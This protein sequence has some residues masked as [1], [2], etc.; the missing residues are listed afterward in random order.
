M[1]KITSAVFQ[2]SDLAGAKRREFLGAAR[3]LPP[4]PRP[5]DLAVNNGHAAFPIIAAS[6]TAPGT[7]AS[8]LVDGNY[9]YNTDPPNRW[10]TTGSPHRAD[11]VTIDFGAARVLDSVQLYLLDDSTGVRAPASYRLAVWRNGSWR[12]LAGEHPTPARPAGHRANTVSFAPVSASRLL[13]VLVPQPGAAVGMTEVE[14]W[15]NGPAPLAAPTAPSPDRAWGARASASFTSRYDSF[16]EINDMVVAFS[17]Y[18]RNRWTSYGSPNRS[19]WIELDFPAARMVSRVELDL[20]GD[21]GGTRAPKRYT[22]QYRSGTDWVDA[23]VLSQVPVAPQVSSANTVTIAPV[24]T[25]GI[26]VV[27]EP[28]TPA[29]VGVTEVIIRGEN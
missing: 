7:A 25:A 3:Q 20:W 12:Q 4:P 9:W 24:S 13:V 17:R 22:V 8:N 15:G 5:V 19:D 27:F 23:R 28:D 10:T 26:R 29:A 11:S 16:S 14:A 1:C 6:Y 21:G 18:S 2:A